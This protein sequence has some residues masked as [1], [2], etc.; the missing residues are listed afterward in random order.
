[1]NGPL[2]I[3]HLEDDRFDGELLKRLL[4][5]E[6]L[7][8]EWVR[9]ESSE[10]FLR[11]LKEGHFD[12]ILSDYTLPSFNGLEALALAQRD[13]PDTP[14]IFVSGTIDEDVAV[15]SLKQGASDYVFK[16]RLS[17]L[18]PAV[19]RSVR[20]VEERADS[21]RAEEA[22][23]ESE[24]KYRQVF[25][26][27]NEA[28]FVLDLA[29]GRII[30]ANQRAEQLV[31]LCR[32]EIIGAKHQ[33]FC[34]PENFEEYRKVLSEVLEQ[35][36]RAE[37]ETKIV[38]KDGKIVP[39]MVRASMLE[40]Y[41]HHLVLCLCSDITARK[42]VED[43][44]REQAKLLDLMSD[45]I[46]STDLEGRVRVWNVA[47]TELYGWSREEAVGR[48]ISELILHETGEFNTAMQLTLKN[49]QWRGDMHLVDKAN[50]EL[51]V[52]SKW[53]VVRDERGEPRAVLIVNTAVSEPS[54]N[55]LNSRD[56]RV[57]VVH[58]M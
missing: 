8:H 10:A 54:V 37:L 13:F 34:A 20:D 44:L 3:L 4:S 41:G 27:M 30:D 6:G 58:R 52:R 57:D 9:V 7:V 5:H 35:N 17:R 25:E 29:S 26:S 48:K 53:S 14:F 22:M 38:R 45:A 50:Q 21:R 46:F 32:S 40:L 49:G 11:A 16:N 39:V 12:L 36:K 2:R 19:R 33:K 15:E 51:V 18:A 1:M 23:R 42:Q 31:G 28:A 56:R 47:A 43:R 24:R 55:R